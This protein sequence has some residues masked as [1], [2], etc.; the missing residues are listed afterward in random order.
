MLWRLGGKK[1]DFDVPTAARFAWQHDAGF[2]A[3]DELRLFDNARDGTVKTH[4]RSRVL[5]LSLDESRRR[6]T[7]TQKF[8]HPELGQ[9]DAMGNAQRLANGNVF[10][11]WGTAKRVTELSPAGEVLFD[12]TLPEVSYRGYRQLWR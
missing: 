10:V 11:G 8:Q 1:S 9:A 7:L 4:S 12:A 3:A 6:A 5:W 2:E